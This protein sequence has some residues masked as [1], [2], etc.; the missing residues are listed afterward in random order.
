MCVSGDFVNVNV[1]VDRVTNTDNF[2][3]EN[4]SVRQA[5]SS[6]LSDRVI[7]IENLNIEQTTKNEI[8]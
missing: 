3:D 5:Q 1:N 4:I 8:V 2:V 7:S 6:V